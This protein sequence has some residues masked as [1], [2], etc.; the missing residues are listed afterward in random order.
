MRFILSILILLLLTLSLK[1]C[2]DRA[3]AVS[4]ERQAVVMADTHQ[5]HQDNNTDGCSPFCVCHCCHTH[6]QPQIT[7]AAEHAP[8]QE[9]TQ[10]V[11]LYKNSFI[12][13][14]SYSIWQPPKVA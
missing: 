5:D 13:S 1:P 12:S 3:S 9:S 6:L 11:D 4:S 8:V 14:L 10:D 2:L 7:D